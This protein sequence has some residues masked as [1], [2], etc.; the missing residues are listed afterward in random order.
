[1]NTVR[2]ELVHLKSSFSQVAKER[3]SFAQETTKAQFFASDAKQKLD[4]MK[5]KVGLFLVSFG[6]I[7]YYIHAVDKNEQACK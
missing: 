5:T 1:M 6:E 4:D 2:Q 3:E 7:L